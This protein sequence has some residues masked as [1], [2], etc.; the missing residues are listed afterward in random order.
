MALVPVV[1]N[2]GGTMT[3]WRGQALT[4][5][6][7]A[8]CPGLRWGDPAKAESRGRVVAA[9]NEELWKAWP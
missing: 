9:A 2:A 7:H 5:Q 3:D 4:L 8:P 1:T 6:S